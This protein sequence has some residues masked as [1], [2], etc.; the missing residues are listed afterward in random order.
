LYPVFINS[1]R[2]RITYIFSEYTSHIQVSST[3]RRSTRGDSTS[4]QSLPHPGSP[5]Q[6]MPQPSHLGKPQ[7]AP[8]PK[9]QNASSAEIRISGTPRLDFF[10][11]SLMT[12][13]N[14]PKG[15]NL[16]APGRAGAVSGSSTTKPWDWASHCKFNIAT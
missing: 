1:P 9:T 10:E 12:D 2:A 7:S 4:S 8:S 13:R 5:P 3:P 6:S 16:N 11:A 15:P 14:R